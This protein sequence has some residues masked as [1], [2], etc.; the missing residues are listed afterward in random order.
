MI[1]L[2]AVSVIDQLA[3]TFVGVL[4]AAGFAVVF[5]TPRRYLAHTLLVGTLAAL[6]I[7]ALPETWNVGFRTFVVALGIGAVSHLFARRTSAP[8]QCFL[9]PGVMFLVPG[10]YIYRSFSAALAGDTGESVALGLA[11]MLITCGTSLGLLVANWVV[12][13]KKTL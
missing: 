1:T 13:A 11:A 4:G 7:T 10:T 8:A 5:R 3:N 6:A 12:P 2:D 9:I